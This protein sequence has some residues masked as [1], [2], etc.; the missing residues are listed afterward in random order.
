MEDYIIGVAIVGVILFVCIFLLLREFVC[1]YYK[2]NQ[3][4]K[5]LE[6]NNELLS[7]ILKQMPNASFEEDFP[8]EIL[9]NAKEITSE[10]SE[11]QLIERLKGQLKDDE[12]LVK[13]KHNNRIEAWKKS[14]IQESFNEGKGD[15]FEVL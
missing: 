1:W 6:K 2:I 14:D 10:D 15:K 11:A 9:Q 3:T 7:Q 5:N 12:A 8:A 4:N 13:I